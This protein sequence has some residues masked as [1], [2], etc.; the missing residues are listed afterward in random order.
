MSNCHNAFSWCSIA[1]GA[2]AA[3][4]V[5]ALSAAEADPPVIERSNPRTYHI[6][7]VVKPSFRGTRPDEL[8]IVT[9]LPQSSQYQTV[10]GEKV[11]NGRIR[12]FPLDCG[13]Y[14]FY[15]ARK[16]YPP[17]ILEFDV[18]IYD[19]RTHWDRIGNIPEPSGK[20]SHFTKNG[21]AG[22]R[23]DHPGVVKVSRKLAA[24]SKNIVEYARQA[25][26]FITANFRYK[27]ASD[28]SISTIWSGRHGDCGNLSAVFVSL[29]RARGVPARSVLTLRPDGSAHVWAEFFVDC[30]G[31][32]PVD[33]TADL[34]KGDFRHFGNI[35]R[36]DCVV[37]H[38]DLYFNVFNGRKKVVIESLQ[39]YSFWFWANHEI[40]RVNM[41]MSFRGKRVP[42]PKTR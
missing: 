4:A 9:A 13:R 17:L 19:V 22:I 12:K 38:K 14:A 21:G 5:C 6:R 35:Y 37:M 39:T 3:F 18:T 10:S 29:M 33:V 1:A 31:W 30:V 40:G 32:L 41:D 15:S 23:K 26:L 34:G 42:R 20:Q 16:K 2:W 27:R 25:Y 36:D 8:L 11:S 7:S 24:R 28:S